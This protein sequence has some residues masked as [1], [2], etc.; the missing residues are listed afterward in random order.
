MGSVK[1]EW[2]MFGLGFLSTAK[3][4]LLFPFVLKTFQKRTSEFQV[5]ECI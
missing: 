4:K 3:K 1:G 2:D 5:H